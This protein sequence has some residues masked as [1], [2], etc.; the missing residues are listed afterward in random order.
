[1][2]EY[3]LDTSVIV[4]YASC[5]GDN[6]FIEEYGKDCE[7]LMESDKIKIISKNVEKELNSLKRRRTNLYINIIS[8]LSKGLSISEMESRIE[9]DDNLRKHLQ[10][11][12]KLTRAGKIEENLESF[13]RIEQLF[14]NRIRRVKTQLIKEVI[15]VNSKF[16]EVYPN[17]GH[18]LISWSGLLGE[19]IGNKNDG[20]ILVDCIALSAIRGKLVFTTLD[21]E[22][23]LSKKEEIT[24]FVDEYCS[25][26]PSFNPD[27]EVRHVTE[28]VR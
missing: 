18:Y 3:F 14:N 9:V 4:A 5:F 24:S 8:I 16:N 10:T 1:M 20:K 27:F 23:I 26:I 25:V 21:C 11:L 19:R 15:D 6:D 13:R 28:V 12:I 7:L 22:H 2:L 17:M